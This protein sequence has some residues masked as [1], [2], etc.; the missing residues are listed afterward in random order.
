MKELVFRERQSHRKRITVWENAV[1]LSVPFNTACCS[2]DVS[3]QIVPAKTILYIIS[4]CHTIVPVSVESFS[5]RHAEEELVEF[6]TARLLIMS[7]T[8]CVSV[9]TLP[10]EHCMSYTCS[11]CE[12]RPC[13]VWN[14]T[15][16]LRPHLL[17]SQL[18]N[19]SLAVVNRYRIT[20]NSI[21]GGFF[22]G[23]II[24]ACYLKSVKKNTC[25]T[26]PEQPQSR[27]VFEL[28]S[29]IQLG[30][31]GVWNVSIVPTSPQ[32]VNW[33]L[34]QMFVETKR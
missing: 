19:L 29:R 10:L 20:P 23:T 21:K 2:H 22:F 28:S 14:R 15:R 17:A 31:H 30:D 6:G 11:K 1:F 4:S 25:I 8:C 12:F 13:V 3:S 18:A 24:E 26:V 16:W 32:E 34:K 33:P 7:V 5:G 9:W 27:L